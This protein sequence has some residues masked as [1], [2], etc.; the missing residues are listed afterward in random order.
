MKFIPGSI[1]TGAGS[2]I[3][4]ITTGKVSTL[5]FATSVSMSLSAES[6]PNPSREGICWALMSTRLFSNTLIQKPFACVKDNEIERSCKKSKFK[7]PYYFSRN[8][9][10]T[11]K[12]FLSI[13]LASSFSFLAKT[14]LALAGLAMAMQLQS[15]IDMAFS[16]LILPVCMA[17]SVVL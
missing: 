12:G 17:R 15:T 11:S 5:I 8:V 4:C 14:A 3:L 16:H 13:S 6:F 10:S 1:F 2:G 9:I 7:A